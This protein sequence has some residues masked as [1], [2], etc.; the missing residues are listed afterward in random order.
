[1]DKSE[2]EFH[3]IA[4]SYLES[5][6]ERLEE[7]DTEG[8]LDMTQ[9]EGVL[10]IIADDTKTFIINKH[11]ASQEIWLASPLS[12]GLHFK[13]AD[14]GRDWKLSDG[15]RLSVVISEELSQV[16]GSEFDVATDL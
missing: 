10:K 8:L 6:F 12:G 9:Q 5:L 11:A 3:S 16:T 2:S 15:R 4:D 7:Q 14:K 13:P 1:M